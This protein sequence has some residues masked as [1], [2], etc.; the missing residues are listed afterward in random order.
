MCVH[1]CIMLFKVLHS[2]SCWTVFSYNDNK[3]FWFWF[4]F[5]CGKMTLRSTW[6]S[7]GAVVVQCTVASQWE[8]HG[9]DSNPVPFW[10]LHVLPVHAWVLSQYSCFLPCLIYPSCLT[11]I[12]QIVADL[13]LSNIYKFCGAE[14]L[15]LIFINFGYVN[16]LYL[17][18]FLTSEMT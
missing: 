8:G 1:V 10:S 17:H 16:I 9:F 11:I 2:K 3:A 4:W 6:C 5:W 12:S 15:A 18:F 13:A 7:G 14:L